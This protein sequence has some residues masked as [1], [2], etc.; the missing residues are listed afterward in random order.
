MTETLYFDA[1]APVP[2]YLRLP[3]DYESRD[4][5]PVLVGLHGGGGD[6]ERFLS[7]RDLFEAPEFI[8]ATPHAPY[9][10]SDDGKLA[11]EWSLWPSGDL[12]MM[13]RGA[14][15][16]E[17]WIAACVR[18]LKGQYPNSPIYL[19]G[20]SQGAIITYRAGI[21][22]HDLLDG[23]VILSGPGLYEPLKTPWIDGFDPKWPSKAE[24]SAA[25]GL[26]VFIAHGREDPAVKY[27]LAESSHGVL[28]AAG[29]EVEFHAF[30][31]GHS[32]DD[33]RT[34]GI[35]EKLSGWLAE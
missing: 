15:A 21:V 3:A 16:S 18:A 20:F 22:H 10:F 25:S 4:D 19:L 28:A 8:F 14:A 24:L 2:C 27:S 1:S 17:Q 5:W 7:V 29:F 11:F 33:A 35:F 12:E 13:E 23:V 31:G 9:P 32:V 26:R 30:S 34:D 6:A